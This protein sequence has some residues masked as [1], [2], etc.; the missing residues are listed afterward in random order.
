MTVGG[1]T[2]ITIESSRGRPVAIAL[3]P[4]ASSQ[5]AAVGYDAATR[6]LVI[7]FRSSDHKDQVIYSYDGVPPELVRG[8]LAAASPGSFFRRHIRQGDYPYR[9]HETSGLLDGAPSAA[10]D[11]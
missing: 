2:C 9:R 7:K 11:R 4:V 8:L 3:I 6:E 5:L 1:A 10:G